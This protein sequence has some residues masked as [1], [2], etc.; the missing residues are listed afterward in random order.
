MLSKTHLAIGVASSLTILAPD[1]LQELCPIVIGASV[2]SINNGAATQRNF[3]P[4]VTITYTI[5]GV[6]YE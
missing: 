6:G 2:G 1:T 3:L 4:K 5:S